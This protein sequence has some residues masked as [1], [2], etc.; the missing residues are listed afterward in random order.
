MFRKLL[1]ERKIIPIIVIVVIGVGVISLFQDCEMSTEIEDPYGEREN[2]DFNLGLVFEKEGILGPIE[3]TVENSGYRGKTAKLNLVGDKLK[4]KLVTDVPE[5]TLREVNDTLKIIITGKIGEEALE[6][7]IPIGDYPSEENQPD[8]L[9]RENLFAVRLERIVTPGIVH[10]DYQNGYR[11]K[12]TIRFSYSY[13][14]VLENQSNL[15]IVNYEQG[16]RIQGKLKWELNMEELE[17]SMRNP[18]W[19]Y[20]SL[21]HAGR[22]SKIVL[23]GDF[24]A[25]VH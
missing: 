18:T 25:L 8:S 11:V 5:D 4:L 14:D 21:G 6:G 15:Q 17:E 19:K 16:R 20:D 2:V 22:P 23:E 3:E 10:P 7:D 24:N 12:D 1:F 13:G 9:Y